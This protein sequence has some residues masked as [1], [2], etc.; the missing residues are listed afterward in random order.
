MNTISIILSTKTEQFNELN[1]PRT[2]ANFIP[3]GLE[4]PMGLVCNKTYYR[5]RGN[6]LTAFRVVMVAIGA[7]HTSP[8]TTHY[9]IQEPNKQ[10]YWENRQKFSTTP[11][12][13]SK[14]DFLMHQATGNNNVKLRWTRVRDAYPNLAYAAV[15]GLKGKLWRWDSA[16]GCPTNDF[17]PE[18]KFFVI[19]EDGTYI[20]HN[21]EN[22]KIST[23]R[24]EVIAKQLNDM[25][26][27]DFDDEPNQFS[28]NILPS[29]EK[30]VTMLKVEEI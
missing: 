10:P 9:F 12:F 30:R 15:V 23:S 4:I 7:D 3:C 16:K 24:S 25:E 13:E 14:E 2:N 26:V 19:T 28:V 29:R 22:G 8:C 27:V 20:V 17:N 6:S 1:V 5:Q 11:I 21:N 18:I